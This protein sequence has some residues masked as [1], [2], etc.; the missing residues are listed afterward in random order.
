MIRSFPEILQ[1]YYSLKTKMLITNYSWTVISKKVIKFEIINSKMWNKP[2][3][4][5]N[6]TALQYLSGLIKNLVKWQRILGT[7]YGRTKQ[8][9]PLYNN[10]L[11]QSLTHI[12]TDVNHLL[13]TVL[14][15][16]VMERFDYTIKILLKITKRQQ[17][18]GWTL[19]SLPSMQ[20]KL[21]SAVPKKCK[22]VINWTQSFCK[23]FHIRS[24][25]NERIWLI[26]VG[27]KNTFPFASV[28]STEMCRKFEEYN[29]SQN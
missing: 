10:T 15:D 4:G 28:K 11:A 1:V 29:I 20:E 21:F 2:R 23:K 17:D 25:M 9:K 13:M 14:K 7:V 16:F 24:G 6:F 12:N 18:S 27:I 8:G 19:S 5:Q 26:N 22:A 3:S